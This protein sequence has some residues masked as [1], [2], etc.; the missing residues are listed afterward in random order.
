MG[1]KNWHGGLVQE[2]LLDEPASIAG[3]LFERRLETT[4]RGVVVDRY[5]FP[6]QDNGV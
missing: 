4:K 2:D 5:R 1:Q 3:L 6:P